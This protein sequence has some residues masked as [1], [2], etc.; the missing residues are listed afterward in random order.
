MLCDNVLLLILLLVELLLLDSD[1]V[2]F[3]MNM[4]PIAT[5]AAGIVEA[6]SVDLLGSEM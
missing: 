4:Y 3:D 5:M 6:A 1:V 2:P